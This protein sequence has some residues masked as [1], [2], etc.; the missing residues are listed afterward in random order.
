M[1]IFDLFSFHFACVNANCIK[2][3]TGVYFYWNCII[4][5]PFS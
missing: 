4:S 2:F 1:D 3:G 5:P